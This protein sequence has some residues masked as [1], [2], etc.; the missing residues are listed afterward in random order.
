VT[1][2][3][4]SDSNY[5]MRALGPQADQTAHMLGITFMPKHNEAA[6]D[7]GTQAIRE[8]DPTYVGATELEM[9]NLFIDYKCIL[10]LAA[11]IQMAGPNLNPQ[12]FAAALHRTV[13]PNP[14]TAAFE[15][16]A[17]FAGG[18]YS[19]TT[20]GAEFWWSN[21][22]RAPGNGG[23]GTWCYIAGGVRQRAGSWP[24]GKTNF[25]DPAA[26]DSGAR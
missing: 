1:S 14:K 24:K 25:F 5:V 13:F 26:C 21:S 16:D 19:M 3:V 2:Y 22:A 15:G 18:S 10:L 11:G 20:D 23:T 8:I 17:G 4:L 7:S 9:Q 12:T 6:L